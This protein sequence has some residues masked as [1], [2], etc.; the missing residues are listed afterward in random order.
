M[1]HISTCEA[2]FWPLGLFIAII[3]TKFCTVS[4]NAVLVG[5]W[6]PQQAPPANWPSLQ[7]PCTF[8]LLCLFL[9]W[10]LPLSLILTYILPCIWVFVC[11]Y[12]LLDAHHFGFRNCVF[13]CS[14]IIHSV[15]NQGL[16]MQ[17]VF[18]KCVVNW[19]KSIPAGALWQIQLE[20]II[21][22]NMWPNYSKFSIVFLL[23]SSCV[24]FSLYRNSH[25]Y[26][27]LSRL[28][29]RKII[30]KTKDHFNYKML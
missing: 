3:V 25:N 30:F 4:Q 17:Q 5:P 2:Q 22:L 1:L 21:V 23:I 8:P 11:F 18:D 27:I 12:A 24:F 19:I 9:E 13:F 7:R 6:L 29:I 15:P 10:P 14:Y 28:C 26:F 16:F 20:G